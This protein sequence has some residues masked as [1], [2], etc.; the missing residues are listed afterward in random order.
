MLMRKFP[1]PARLLIVLALAACAGSGRSGPPRDPNV[2]TL[3]ELNEV[4][5]RSAFDAIERLRPRWLTVRGRNGSLPGVIW[6][7]RPNYRIE[8][9][10]SMPLEQIKEMAFVSAIDATTM[11]G[12]GYSG[13]AIQVTS[14]R[15]R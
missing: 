1:H 7:G 15:R 8:V 4:S 5:D 12:T 6:D 11:Y 14:R 10:R 13:G 3:Q 9:L 2:I